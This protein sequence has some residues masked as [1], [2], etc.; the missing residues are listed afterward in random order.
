M[1]LQR[2]DRMRSA[3]VGYVPPRIQSVIALP[4]L[5][6]EFTAP[7]AYASVWLADLGMGPWKST[8]RQTAPFLRLLPDTERDDAEQKP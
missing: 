1:A 6:S 5:G 3:Q 7:L 4:Y 2:I 8:V